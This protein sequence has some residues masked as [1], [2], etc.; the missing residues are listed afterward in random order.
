MQRFSRLVKLY[1][2]VEPCEP[3]E[4]VLDLLRSN[5]AASVPISTILK[6]FKYCV[7]FD[8]KNDAYVI[9]RNYLRDISSQSV[10]DHLEDL[11]CH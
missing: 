8:L 2:Q 10:V 7:K 6:Q 5:V 11:P 4:Q 9:L 3:D 1:L